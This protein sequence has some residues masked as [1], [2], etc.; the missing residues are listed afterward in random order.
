MLTFKVSVSKTD[1]AFAVSVLN[2]AKAFEAGFEDFQVVAPDAEV[3]EG[4]YIVT[5]S[6]KEQV[7]RT[8]QKH[9]KSDIT[10][11]EIPFYDVGNTSGGRTIYIG[12]ELN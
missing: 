10:V 3:Y 1:Q 7:L 2:N 6:T 4:S 5:P 11:T 9:L 8:A 12:K